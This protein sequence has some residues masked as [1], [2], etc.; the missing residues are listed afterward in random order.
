MVLSTLFRSPFVRVPF[1]AFAVVATV[2]TSEPAGW[3]LHAETP[4]QM[5]TVAAGDVVE[6]SFTWS[7]SESGVELAV[8]LDGFAPAK[9]GAVRILAPACN[10]DARFQRRDDGH[11]STLREDG[12][13][14]GIGHDHP[15]A[16]GWCRDKGLAVL[17]RIENDGATSLT[18]DATVEVEARGP[19]GVTEAPAGAFVD[20]KAL[21]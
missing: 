13:T 19:G 9:G 2:A 7:S 8:D 18:F 5:L 21:P 6:R 3:T 4:A 11:W 1:L 12:T 14:I 20:V 15:R 16:T 17:V 10:I